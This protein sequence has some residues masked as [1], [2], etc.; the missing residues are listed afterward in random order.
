[1]T[2][3]VTAPTPFTGTANNQV[4]TTAFVNN[5]INQYANNVAI[6]GGII[7]VFSVASNTSVTANSVSANTIST[8]TWTIREF[9]G[10]LFFQASGTNIAKLDTSGNFT[11]IGNVTGFGTL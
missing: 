4:A 2:G 9:G 11:T 7:S 6:T 1:M 5:Q 3:F 10:A 8:P